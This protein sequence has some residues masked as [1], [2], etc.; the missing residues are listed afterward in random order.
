MRSGHAP[1][2]EKLEGAMPSRGDKAPLSRERVVAAGVAVADGEGLAA[3]TM[4]RVADVLDCEAMSLY[5]HVKDKKDLLAGLAEAVVGEVLL[6]ARAP[7]IGDEAQDW[8]D[9]VRARCLGARQ[10]MHRHPWAPPLL[11][12]QPTAPPSVYAVYEELVSTMVGAGFGY[13]LA[14]RAIHALGSLVLGFAQE[15]FEPAVDDDGSSPQEAAA[16]AAHLPHLSR[17][18]ELALHETE[19][20]LSVCDTQAEFEFTLGLVLDGLEAR[21][22]A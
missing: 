9:V 13:D 18:G 15:L 3:V 2:E 1:D 6:A 11:V 4:R 7:G 5:H 14:H 17:L 22:V 20:A 10:V 21:R 16:M 8:R 19:G 12:S